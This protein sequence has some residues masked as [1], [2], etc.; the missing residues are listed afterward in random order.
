MPARQAQCSDLRPL[1]WQG[2]GE[3]PEIRLTNEYTSQ[4]LIYLR[5]R[6]YSPQS[7]RFLTK[8]VWP[9][10]YARPLSL[11]GWNYVEA[12]PV[13]LTDPSGMV[14]DCD[15]YQRADL[16]QWLIDEIN[17]NRR[18]Y[19]FSIL[20]T[21]AHF[22]EY[23]DILFPGLPEFDLPSDLASYGIAYGLFADVVKP[24]GLWDFKNAIFDIVGRNI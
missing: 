9:G 4:G 20:W 3:N 16:T 7:G 21:A 6:W 11:N 1:P 23:N 10:D 8:D 12:N 18:G 22:P 17:E 5:A 13:N 24:R 15:Q 2:R 14:P 19:I